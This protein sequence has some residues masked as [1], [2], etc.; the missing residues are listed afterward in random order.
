MLTSITPG[1]L[2]LLSFYYF[3][4]T[5][6]KLEQLLNTKITDLTNQVENIIHLSNT[7]KI[8]RTR[9]IIA[10]RKNRPR[11]MVR[12][13]KFIRERSGWP[14]ASLGRSN[15]KAYAILM[16]H[17]LTRGNKINDVIFCPGPFV[18][19]RRLDK[20]TSLWCS[21]RT[22]R[23]ATRQKILGAALQ[24]FFRIFSYDFSKRVQLLYDGA[25]YHN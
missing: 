23:D 2:D 12:Q 17:I 8:G 6:S 14:M 18:P 25:F 16:Y 3:I 24:N 13:M 9:Q 10:P 15:I 11:L 21:P 7:T 4:I 22:P 5:N 1:Y 20:V 19:T